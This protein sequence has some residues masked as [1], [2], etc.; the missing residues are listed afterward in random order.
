MHA[1]TYERAGLCLRTKAFLRIRNSAA[2]YLTS[3][4]WNM[5]IKLLTVTIKFLLFNCILDNNQQ[6]NV[7][8]ESNIGRYKII[9]LN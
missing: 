1:P 4:V 6:K 2:V 8:R 5:S 3:N 7:R 9:K